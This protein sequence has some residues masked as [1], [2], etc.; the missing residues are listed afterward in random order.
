VDVPALVGNNARLRDA[1]GW[2]PEK[3]VRDLIED[4]VS[5]WAAR[6]TAQV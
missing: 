4:L 5:Y 6:P 3:T 1:T 2:E